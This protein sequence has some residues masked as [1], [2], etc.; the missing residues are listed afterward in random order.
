MMEPAR[1]YRSRAH[2]AGTNSRERTSSG[3]VSA[4]VASKSAAMHPTAEAGVTAT[5]S[6]SSTLRPHWYCKHKSKRRDVGEAPHTP[7]L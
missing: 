1:G 6:V 7:L 3:N 5:T 4:A 2:A